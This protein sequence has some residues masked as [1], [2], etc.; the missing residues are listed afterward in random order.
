MIIISI[1]VLKALIESWTERRVST[2]RTILLKCLKVQIDTENYNFFILNYQNN[3]VES[4]SPVLL[5][6]QNFL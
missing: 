2:E 4:L 3:Y 6:Y 1:D 5:E